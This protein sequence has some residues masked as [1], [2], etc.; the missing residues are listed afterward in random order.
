MSLYRP[1]GSAVW[2]YDFSFAGTRIR[3]S[4][5]QTSKTLARQVYERRKQELRDGASGIRRQQKPEL[6]SKALKD[7]VDS[8]QLHWSESMKSIANYAVQ[9]LTPVLGK[10]LLMEVDAADVRRYQ[11]HRLEEGASNRTVNIEVSIL[12]QTMR[13]RGYWARIATELKMLP[14][15]QDVGRALTDQE[16]SK[17]L[18]ECGR[19][20]SRSLLPFV[21]L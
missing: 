4:T 9:H 8:K 13:R 20:A 21:L 11:H 1:K 2:V 12:R 15:R 18:L 17:L 6:V 7:W 5:K 10:Q 14:E 19:S 16:E 3:G